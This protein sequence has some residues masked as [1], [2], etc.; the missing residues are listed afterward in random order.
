MGD[1]WVSRYL[2][3]PLYILSLTL[4]KSHSRLGSVGHPLPREEGH[5]CNPAFDGSLASREEV[6]GYNELGDL[7]LGG[8]RGVR[9][10]PIS[11]KKISS[12]L[13]INNTSWRCRTDSSI[14]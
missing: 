5:V 8:I 1:V 2:D 10:Y 12:R 11:S 9:G 14:V 3:R 7:G 13:K 6:S 4:V